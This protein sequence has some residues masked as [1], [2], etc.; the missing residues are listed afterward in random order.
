MRKA[1]IFD[2]DGTLVDS[3]DLH[4]QA[5]AATLAKYGKQI[6]V[7]AVRRQIGKGGDL[8]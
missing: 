7:K 1:F 3:V 4:A 5:W 2:I 8:P 6:D